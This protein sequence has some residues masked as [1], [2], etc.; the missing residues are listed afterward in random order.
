MIYIFKKPL[1]YAFCLFAFVTACNLTVAASNSSA[2]EGRLSEYE[3]KVA[4][5]YN[6]LKFVEWGNDVPGDPS[7]TIA[8]C[9]LGEDPFGNALN[10]VEGKTVKGIK[11]TVQHV[12]NVHDVA[13]RVLF[14]SAS[15]K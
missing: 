9:V 5:I 13:C 11:F 4:F 15:E 6:F 1:R 3:V 14:I 8:L 10:A 2:E 7:G 12:N